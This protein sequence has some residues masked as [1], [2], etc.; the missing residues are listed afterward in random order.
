MLAELSIENIAVI[1]RAQI[2]FD[3]GLNIFT[4]ETGAGKSILIGA[5]GAALGSRTSKD[6][7]RTGE[8]RAKVSALFTQI[9]DTVAGKLSALGIDAGEGELALS[10]EI[11]ADG[12]LCRINGMSSTVAQL[13]AAGMLLP[14]THGQQDSWLLSQEETHLGFIDQFGGLEA[15]RKQYTAAF[16]RMRVLKSRLSSLESDEAARAR[17]A[18]LLRYQVNEIE[19]ARLTDGEEEELSARRR[20]IRNAEQLTELF[21]HCHEILAGNDEH[22][23]VISQLNEAASDLEAVKRYIEGFS[24]SAEA[25]RNY[26]YELDDLSERLR[27]QLE[28]LDFNP[29]E[30]DEIEDRLETIAKLKK[31]Y[32]SSISEILAFG[33]EAAQ[34]LADIEGFEQDASVLAAELAE[35]EDTAQKLSA[36]LTDARRDAAERLTRAVEQEL[37]ELDMP[38]ARMDVSFSAKSLSEDGGDAVEFLLSVNPGEALKPLSKIASGGEMSRIMLGIK[39]VLSGREEI[40]TLIFD[41]IDAGISGRAASKVGAKLRA[42]ARGRQ[43]ICV[44]H[45]AQV[46]AYGEHH[47]LIEKEI[48]DGRTFT[49]IKPLDEQ[50][51][52]AE[53]AR[54]MNGE[55]ITPLALEN[56]RELLAN[57]RSLSAVL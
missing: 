33:E 23:G 14:Q 20:V 56:A 28:E 10:R 37:H 19:S 9:T 31:K 8:T 12:N 48:S 44:T 46:A 16:E 43:I 5:I 29:R 25:V 27:E 18:D 4:G 54:I 39:G 50:G 32:G 30:L 36:A 47:L 13:R 26:Q 22:A 11:T 41:E 57:T 15:Q 40:G 2:R 52:V 17:K 6:L 3:Q 49:E 42:A 34:Q 51:R 45:L 38:H 21:S 55:P 7:I 35:A 24:Q 1:R 53:L